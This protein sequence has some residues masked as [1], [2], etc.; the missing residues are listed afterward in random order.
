MAPAD[1]TPSLAA[2]RIAGFTVADPFNAQ[3][4]LLNVGK[5]LRFTGDVWRDHACCVVFMHENDLEQ[6][7][8][9]SQAVVN[10][11]V[12]AQLWIPS[13]RAETASLLAQS[14]PHRYTPHS[15]E[16]L[17]KVLTPSKED[18]PFYIQNNAIQNPEWQN[19]R[20]DFQPYPFASYTEELVRQLQVM[21]FGQGSEFL[22]H[23]DPSQI[24]SDLV[25]N[26]FV[27]KA[28]T[29]LG[30]PELFGLDSSYIRQEQVR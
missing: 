6:R 24:A 1:M 20:I 16:I 29:Q 7:P 10:A 19:Q 25:D 13:N 5:I 8:Q 28:I 17:A 14:N 27:K 3:A 22:A 9:W 21:Q 18:Q 30:G 26:S 11:I 23:L 2:K 15:E 12:K 4:E